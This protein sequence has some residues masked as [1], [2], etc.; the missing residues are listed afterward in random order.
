M[1]V[2]CADAP[3]HEGR[4]TETFCVLSFKDVADAAERARI[5]NI[6]GRAAEGN[7]VEPNTVPDSSSF[8]LTFK[9]SDVRT[10][11][12]IDGDLRWVMANGKWEQELNAENP[13]FSVDYDT[14]NLRAKIE[15][16]L[17][18]TTDAG[19]KVFWK[20]EGGEEKEVTS[21]VDLSGT[22]KIPVVFPRGK[23][24][25]FTRSVLKDVQ[26]YKKVS[27]DGDVIDSREEE[28]RQP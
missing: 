28:Y 3:S 4:I 10:L 12:K 7:A 21:S 1:S 14:T 11:D 26:K 15:T 19:A 24:F 17:T 13:K 8:T 16:I 18:L 22:V 5:C 6:V 20:F 25:I 27:V 23:T 2:G 9:I